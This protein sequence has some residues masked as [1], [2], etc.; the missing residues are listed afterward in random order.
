LLLST[1]IGHTATTIRA[2]A[3]RLGLTVRK[4]APG[5]VAFD[6]DD[7]DAVILELSRELSSVESQEVRCLTM[8]A[9]SLADVRWLAQAM[10]APS[11][12]VACARLT[13]QDLLPLFDD[14]EHC[15]HSVY[16]PIVDL[17]DRSTVGFEALLRA[18]SPDGSP[19]YPDVLF[20]SAEASG[21]THLIDR[22]G[23]TTALHGAAS[24]LGDRL[25]F[26]NFIPTSIYRPEVCLRTTEAA[27]RDAGLRLDQL[28]FEVT[29]GHQ[30]KDVAHLERVFD[31]YRERNC[32]VALDD[33]GAGY[34]SLNLLVQL[35]PDVVKLDKDIVQ[36]LPSPTSS[37]VVEAVV[38]ITHGY[39]GRVL[40]ECVET[41]E[42]AQAAR[43]LGVDL[44]QGWLF[45]R[46]ER[47]ELLHEDRALSP[48]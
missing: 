7:L 35:R 8:P 11:L 48:G 1:Q 43:D 13:H 26:V 16:Q 28:V 18:I 32:Q 6:G 44:A 45:G 4:L 33:L 14:E 37:A 34:S 15:F 24:W 40:A 47:A 46:P 23:R 22:I 31:Y 39:G 5:L 42:Q 41:P 2:V 17:A 20:P 10:Q 25:L 36:D 29:E 3:A 21:W 30:V 19:I 38:R 12:A 27:A 9:S